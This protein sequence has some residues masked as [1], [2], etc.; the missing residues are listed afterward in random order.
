[1]ARP[2]APIILT[3]WHLTDNILDQSGAK[4]AELI[5]LKDVLFTVRTSNLSFFF[6]TFLVFSLCSQ[7]ANSKTLEQISIIYF[8]QSLQIFW[9]HLTHK[10]D[11]RDEREREVY[12]N[13]QHVHNVSI[14]YKK[15]T[16]KLM[17]RGTHMSIITSFDLMNVLYTAEYVE[18]LPN[19]SWFLIPAVMFL[20]FS[21][22]TTTSDCYTEKSQRKRTLSVAK[23]KKNH[24]ENCLSIKIISMALMW[25]KF[26]NA[27]FVIFLL[28]KWLENN[29]CPILTIQEKSSWRSGTKL[30][31]VITQ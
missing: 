2:P 11:Q 6:G 19:K 4:N 28:H 1:M 26:L 14:H 24:S 3:A 10:I 13:Y 18:E 7:F 21:Q 27:H 15:S 9:V 5:I 8:Y 25:T 29:C 20:V 22:R 31:L 23:P 30:V 17:V 16:E 12:T